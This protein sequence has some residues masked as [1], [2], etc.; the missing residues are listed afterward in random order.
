[1]ANSSIVVV[2]EDV[3]RNGE[4]VMT[5]LKSRSKDRNVEREGS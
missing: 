3:Y 1:M 2:G 4:V 5:G